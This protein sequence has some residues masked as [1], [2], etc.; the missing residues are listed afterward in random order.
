MTV[1]RDTL[2]LD[3]ALRVA[4]SIPEAEVHSRKDNRCPT[5]ARVGIFAEDHISHFRDKQKV[6]VQI[7]PDLHNRTEGVFGKVEVSG[8]GIS[9]QHFARHNRAI[10]E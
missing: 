7:R 3:A 2:P 4:R 1:A 8:F 5:I 10:C 6:S 9:L